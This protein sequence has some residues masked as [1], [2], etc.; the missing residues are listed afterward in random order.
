MPVRR[1]K[2]ENRRG[3]TRTLT[4]EGL[5]VGD[6]EWRGFVLKFVQDE[7]LEK[8]FGDVSEDPTPFLTSGGGN[9]AGQAEM[10]KRST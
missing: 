9:S 2:R 4:K 6:P 10:P 3:Q 7:K 1:R 8:R 5:V